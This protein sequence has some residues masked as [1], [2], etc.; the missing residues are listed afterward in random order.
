[1]IAVPKDESPSLLNLVIVGAVAVATITIFFGIGF[2]W[3]ALPYPA[4]PPADP[5]PSAQALEAHEVPPSSNSDTAWGTS[6]APADKLAASSTSGAPSGR[7]ARA[8]EATALFSP[9]PADP[10]TAESRIIPPARVTHAKRIGVSW[11]RRGRTVR[12]WVVLWQ[13]PYTY[14]GPNPGGGFY[15]PPNINVGY[16][17]PK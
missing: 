9:M 14:P 2:L 17:N 11:H 6:S 7:E 10:R 13:R 5:V 12:R 1:M 4:T 15:G 16:I 8:S 3:L